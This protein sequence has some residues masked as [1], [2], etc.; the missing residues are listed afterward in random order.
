MRKRASLGG[1]GRYRYSLQRAWDPA[2]PRALFVLLNPS[3]ADAHLD[4]P[5]LRRCLGF[6]RGAGAGALEVVNLFALRTPDPRALRTADDPVGPGNRRAQRRAV[7]RADLVILG[8]GACAVAEEAS[9]GF[10]RCLARWRMANDPP[11]PVWCLGTTGSGAPR[12]PLYVPAVT[13]LVPYP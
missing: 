6:A 9:P 3:R 8:W 5:T 1:A 10:L 7:A 11:V 12:H 13:A 4:D 2:G